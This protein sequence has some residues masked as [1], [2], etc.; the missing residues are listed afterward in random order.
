MSVV[1][2]GNNPNGENRRV[3]RQTFQYHFAANS[4]WTGVGSNLVFRG[5]WTA[6]VVKMYGTSSLRCDE[7]LSV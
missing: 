3:R 4:T 5:E 2:W 1:L 7:R 6:T